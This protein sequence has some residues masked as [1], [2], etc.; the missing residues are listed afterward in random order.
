MFF[1]GYGQKMTTSNLSGVHPAAGL[2]PL[3]DIPFFHR[4]IQ[5]TN[6]KNNK[7]KNKE[8]TEWL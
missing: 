8:T 4:H 1:Q 6:I 7:W 5:C 2:T 3:I